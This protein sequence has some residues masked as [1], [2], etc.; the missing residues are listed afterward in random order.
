MERRINKIVNDYIGRF[1]ND[2]K[3]KSETSKDL[4]E[5]IQYVMNYDQLTLSNDVFTKRRRIKNVVP[6]NDRCTAKRASGEQ[7]TR[8]RKNENS[9]YCGTHIKGT[10]HGIVENTIENVNVEKIELW[11]QDIQ[12]IIYYIDKY[13]HIYKME[14]IVSNKTVPQIVGKYEKVGDQYKIVNY[15]G[16]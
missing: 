16:N 13:H 10:P 6:I 7:C 11:A 4:N 8:R 15:Y 2:V 9:C 14:D 3:K 12:G 1:K 5:I